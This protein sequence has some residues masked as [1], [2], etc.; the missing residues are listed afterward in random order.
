M[1]KKYSNTVIGRK[2]HHTTYSLIPNPP[3]IFSPN[4]FSRIDDETP[5]KVEVSQ[6][7]RVY[8]WNEY[9]KKWDDIP[10]AVYWPVDRRTDEEK[11]RDRIYQEWYEAA[12]ERYNEFWYV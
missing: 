10:I 9:E 12:K 2:L 1:D 7:T 8:D 5:V 11:E 4:V 3:I 6:R